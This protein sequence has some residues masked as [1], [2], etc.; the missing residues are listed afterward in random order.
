MHR[1][2]IL[3]FN[4]RELKGKQ[5]QVATL[6]PSCWQKWSKNKVADSYMEE[7]TLLLLRHMHFDPHA[8][9]AEYKFAKIAPFQNAS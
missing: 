9:R 8:Y 3:H 4:S 1:F 2:Q 5:S 6:G 7:S